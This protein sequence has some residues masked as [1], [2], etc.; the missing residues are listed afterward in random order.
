MSKLTALRTE[1]QSDNHQI[2]L[3]ANNPTARAMLAGKTLFQVGSQFDLEDKDV[4]F[5]PSETRPDITLLRLTIKG[6]NYVVYLSKGFPMEKLNDANYLLNCEFRESWLSKKEEDGVTPIYNETTG[7]I[8]LDESKP[9]LS[10]G[11]PSGITIGEGMNV[12][13][14]P[15]VEQK[16]GGAKTRATS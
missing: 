2:V 16:A 13:A 11:K 9:Y 3:A 15:T 14:E 12:F 10:F 7:A 6:V 5:H 1:Q 4:D 8:E